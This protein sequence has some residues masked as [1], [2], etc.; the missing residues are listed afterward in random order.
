[1]KASRNWCLGRR[2][3]ASTLPREVVQSVGHDGV[4]VFCVLLD[5]NDGGKMRLTMSPAEALAW[6]RQLTSHA[7]T[8]A[9]PAPREV[10]Q[11]A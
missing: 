1:M 6:A 5:R 4:E 2:R 11:Q 3:R 7:E 9:L 8:F 10:G